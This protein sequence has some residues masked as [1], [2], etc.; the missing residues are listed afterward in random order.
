[1]LRRMLGIVVVHF[2][3]PDLTAACVR[4]ILREAPPATPIVIVENGSAPG[5]RE[6]LAAAV[7]RLGE[8]VR[9]IDAGG[10]VGFA[11]GCN[12]GIGDCLRDP[13]VD[14]VLLVN[15]DAELVAG[16]IAHLQ[17][18]IA[19]G[20]C[21]MLAARVHRADQRDLVDSLGITMYASA[22]ASNRMD[23]EE[24]LL[25]PTGG[26]A[27]YSRALV[28]ELVARDGHFFDPSFFC[29]AEDTD[30]AWRALLAGYSPEYV[31]ECVAVH[32]GQASSGGGF[33]DF[34]LYHGIRNSLWL[35]VKG[36]PAG[37]LLRLSVRIILLHGGIVVRHG[38]R[39]KLGVLVRLYRDFLRGLPAKLRQ[40]RRIL[41]GRRRGTAALRRFVSD[42]FYERTY[43]RG[44]LQEF[45]RLGFRTHD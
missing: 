6:T 13:A 41:R 7:T 31:D 35:V 24:P 2:N 39:G 11:A 8:R 34:V 10:N 4:S 40:R 18:A 9:L 1:M 22:L 33:N 28:S 12:L 42:H 44:A 17:R 3:T 14:H 27:V 30:V 32:H 20:P 29:Y 23:A 37:L 16:G 38:L 5:N 36:F 26:L 45:L 21:D 19:T 43:L 25:G 15:S